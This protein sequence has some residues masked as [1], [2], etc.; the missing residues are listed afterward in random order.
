MIRTSA[1][2]LEQFRRVLQTEYA[3]AD[4]LI[5]QIKGKPFAPSWQA[6]AGTAWHT[7]LE[8]GVGD[9]PTE[10]CPPD[11]EKVMK[12]GDYWFSRE[13]VEYGRRYVGPG[14]WEVKGTQIF[15]ING[16]KVELVAK[17]DHILGCIIQ[18]NKTRWGKPA[19]CADYEPSL[20]WRVYLQVH[21]AQVM[22]YNLWAFFEPDGGNF[23]QLKDVLSVR[24]YRYPEL[25]VDVR[26]WLGD[27]LWFCRERDLL[28]YLERE[29]TTPSL[30][31][32]A[33]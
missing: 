4:E 1:T 8:T 5:A 24:F 23:C 22:K 18:D 7:L 3:S 28:G 29:G 30:P 32:E 12:C 17:V 19:S 6:N 14:L 16:T 33:A 21:K 15:D 13:S 9:V 10:E 2:T 25:E 31:E 27:F 26:R 11:P 20:Q